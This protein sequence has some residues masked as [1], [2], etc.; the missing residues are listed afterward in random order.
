MCFTRFSG[1]LTIFIASSVF[2]T[3]GVNQKLDRAS[4][5]FG[6]REFVQHIDISPD[7]KS[8]VYLTPN[9]SSGTIAMVAELDGNSAPRPAIKSDGLFASLHWCKFVNSK[10]LICKLGGIH[11]DAD[12]LIPFTRLLAVDIDGQKVQSLGQVAS[13]RD[14]RA[15]QFD[16]KVLDWLSGENDSVL[17]MREYVPEARAFD[18]KLGRTA[19]G[20][21]I[22]EVDTRTLKTSKRE[23]PNSSI[24]YFLTD[25]YGNVR[26]RAYEKRENHTRNLTGKTMFQYRQ[27][28]SMEWLPFSSWEDRAG[29]LPLAIDRDSNSVYALKKMEGRLA[30]FRVSLDGQFRE[31][32]IYRSEKVDVD[33]LIRINR[34]RRAIGV[35]YAEEKRHIIFFDPKYEKIVETVGNALPQF[36]MIDIVETSRDEGRLLIHAGSDSDPGR[37]YLYE[38]A[39]R[40]LRE[41][42]LVRPEL[43]NVKTAAVKPI[44]YPAA[45]GTLIPA[46]LT[47]PPGRENE[48][49]L[50]TIVMPHGGP[51]ARDEWGFDWLSQFLANQGYAVI[52]PNFR[53]S[54]G[55]GDEWR[56]EN[57]YKSWKKSI[58]DVIDAA[59]WM[60]SSGI[61]NKNR[62]AIVGWS[63]GGYAALQSNVV[64]PQLFKAIVAIAPVTDL[65][66][67]K[68]EARDY[69]S[70]T[71]VEQQI[72]EGRHVIEG[73]PYENASKIQAPVLLFHGD[74][75]LNVSVEHSKKMHEKLKK[76][77]K[78]SEFI[79][80]SG[81]EHSLDDSVTRV[82]MLE[83][84]RLFLK[85]KLDEK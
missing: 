65:E 42:L 1:L 49:N 67:V 72:G 7:G 83:K 19:D 37:F 20:Q 29:L 41:L 34:N 62:L 28:D 9:G 75:D 10:R 64:Q 48:K 71:L 4:L 82:K 68:K 66:A 25:G 80:F 6:A 77:N 44:H 76:L 3:D 24:D 53:G 46:Y 58:G 55:Y 21:G 39:T 84:I 17:M 70:A 15:R 47:L 56:Q 35:S 63:Y 18:S 57:G 16:G 32:L 26:I 50:A 23:S 81:F 69:T 74:K 59:N 31:E 27:T 51:S 45:D 33:S 40:S 85:N 38:V 60:V 79:Q 12:F 61:A 5:Q 2:A 36:P 13:L 30:L 52:Q 22:D 43:E 14:T 8:I 11:N 73:S 78:E 54:D